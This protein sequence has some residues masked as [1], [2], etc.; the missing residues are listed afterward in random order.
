M[1]S[2]RKCMYLASLGAETASDISVEVLHSRLVQPQSND[3]SSGLTLMPGLSALASVECEG[4]DCPGNINVPS[5]HTLV[6]LSI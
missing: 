3:P 6:R 1:L 4:S 2:Q 5:M